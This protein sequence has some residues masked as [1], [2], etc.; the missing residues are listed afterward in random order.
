MLSGDVVERPEHFG[1]F[2]DVFDRIERGEIVKVLFSGPPQFGKTTI[3]QH[4]IARA[5]ARRPWLPIVYA[6]YG[7]DVASAKSR[8]MRDLVRKL[9]VEL[10]S[11]ADRVDDWITTQGGGLRARSIGGAVTGQ[12]AKILVV[13]DIHKNRQQAES[14]L[15]RQTAYD[16]FTSVGDARAHPDTSIIVCSTRWH[17][18]D[19]IGRLAALRKP[20]G[21][22]VWEYFQYSAIKEDGKPL[23]Y[24]RP[25]DFLAQKRALS[26]HDWW[27]LW[28][29]RPRPRGDRLFKGVRYYDRLPIRY[30]IG[31]GVDLAYSEKTKACYSA[32]VVLIED[33]DNPG[34]VYV[35]EVLRKQLEVGAFTAALRDVDERWPGT[36]HWFTSTTEKGTAQLMGLLPQDIRVAVEPVLAPADK[37]VRAQP[38]AAAWNGIPDRDIPGRVFVPRPTPERPVPWL[39]EFVDEVGA[40]TGS[41]GETNDQVDAAAS[42][43]EGVRYR[44]DKPKTVSGSGTRYEHEGRGFF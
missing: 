9:G 1:G 31:K 28:M 44:A 38:L 27:S 21:E 17:D 2:A 15:A 25:L 35:V 14:A 22:P 32:G 39:K 23:W 19:L 12:P 11:D 8:D 33:L 34:D 7:D 36:W 42:A 13:D 6:S 26:E 10:R 24:R 43:F 4:G 3:V 40:F 16:W 41:A 29:G 18:D 20:N 30:R 5:I 37:F